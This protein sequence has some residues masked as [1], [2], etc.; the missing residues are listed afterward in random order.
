MI[1]MKK[2]KI[3]LFNFLDCD[4]LIRRTTHGDYRLYSKIKN[5]K[6]FTCSSVGTFS[7]LLAAKRYQ[8]E[9]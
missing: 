8:K 2:R 9:I 4:G 7:S 6:S 1:G 5:G 3:K